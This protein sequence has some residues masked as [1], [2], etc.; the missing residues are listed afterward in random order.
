MI[1]AILPSQYTNPSGGLWGYGSIINSPVGDVDI[2]SLFGDTT[3][4]G[5]STRPFPHRGADLC[6]PGIH[7][8]EVK[9]P[10]SGI[11]YE[12]GIAADHD[13]DKGNYII[14]YH[15]INGM[16]FYFKYFHFDEPP[17]FSKGDMITAG[18]VLGL[19]GTTGASSGDHLHWEIDCADLG[20]VNP[21]A[22]FSRQVTTKE[23]LILYLAGGGSYVN[24]GESPIIQ[25]TDV[26]KLLL[27][28]NVR[29]P[30]TMPLA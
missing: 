18:D 13:A 12:T 28:W 5:Y 25:G 26:V 24:E 29:G 11:V 7:R 4:G 9:S 8:A 20:Y 21:L 14:V 1:P 2:S 10:L 19:V 23:S 3:Y 30:L 6:R 22:M 15:D 27:P 17:F 16:P